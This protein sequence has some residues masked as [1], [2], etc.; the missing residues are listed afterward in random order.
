MFTHEKI[1]CKFIWSKKI[2]SK[3]IFGD[4]RNLHEIS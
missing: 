4:I 1:Y 3:I 2:F